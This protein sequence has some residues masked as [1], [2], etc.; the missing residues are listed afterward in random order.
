MLSLVDCRT[1]RAKSIV[2]D[3][4]KGSR[5]PKLM[6]QTSLGEIIRPQ[7]KT[8]SK[9]ACDL[10]FRSINSK[11]LDV[12]IFDRSG[13]LTLAIEYQGSGHY[14]QTAVKKKALRKAG[15]SL[16]EVPVRFDPHELAEQVRRALPGPSAPR[17]LDSGP[18]GQGVTGPGTTSP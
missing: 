9:E 6:A 16:L 5:S 2:V 12:A 18:V 4:L 7:M 15:V 11:H 10:A 13:R 14:H 17:S 8:G 1:G 3:D